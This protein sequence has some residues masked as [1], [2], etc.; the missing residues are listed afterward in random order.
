MRFTNILYIALCI[1][2]TSKGMFSY[3]PAHMWPPFHSSRLSFAGQTMQYSWLC[4]FFAHPLCQ[5]ELIT[6]CSFG[7]VFE[8]HRFLQTNFGVMNDLWI[9][10]EGV[11]NKGEGENCPRGGKEFECG[12]KR[13]HKALCAN[14]I[15]IKQ[16]SS[17]GPPTQFL[18]RGCTAD[19]GKLPFVV[20]R[21]WGET[22]TFFFHY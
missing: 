9:E 3:V 10:G 11:S 1:V 17:T 15:I 5:L 14:F 2:L 21:S 20:T 7:V 12:M 6:V 19:V 8:Y 16:H 18:M 4:Q 13:S 22:Q